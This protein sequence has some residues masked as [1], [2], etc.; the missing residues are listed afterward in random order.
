MSASTLL[1]RPDVSL[2]VR[3]SW[4]RQRVLNAVR[5]SRIVDPLLPRVGVLA[6]APRRP[7]GIRI[8]RRRERER[9][10]ALMLKIH[11]SRPSRR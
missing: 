3:Q 2:R 5:N 4:V 6:I 11:A 9:R 7:E 1:A 10:D 8:C